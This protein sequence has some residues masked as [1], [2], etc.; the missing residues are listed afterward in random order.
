MTRDEIYETEDAGTV[1]VFE[2]IRGRG[3]VGWCRKTP[4]GWWTVSTRTWER[5]YRRSRRAAVAWL[6]DEAGKIPAD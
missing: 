2:K 5:G 1:F 3:S 6:V 4:L